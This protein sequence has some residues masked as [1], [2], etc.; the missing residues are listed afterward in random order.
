M[1]DGL[2]QVAPDSTGKKVDTSELIVG[3][4][5]VE[6]QRV[7]IGDPT[8]AAGLAA[9]GTPNTDADAGDIALATE[10][11]LKAWNGAS[12]DRLRMFS[13][14]GLQVAPAPAVAATTGAI[15][16]AATTVGP[17]TLNQYDGATV[18]VSG[19]YAGV[20]LSFEASNDNTLWFP[21][22]AVRSDSNIAEI[23]SGVLTAN[24][25]RAWDVELGEALYFRVRSTAWTS[26]SAAINIQ[27]GMFAAAPAMG[28]TA[29]AVYNTTL[30]TFT[31]GSLAYLLADVNG[32]AVIT[33]QG[34][35]AAA[36]AGTPVRIGGTFTT[37]LPTYTTGQQTDLQTTN[38]G[39][40]LVALSSGATAVAVK[41]ASTA[42]AATDPALTVSLSPNSPIVLPTPTASIINSAATTNATSVKAT[43]GTVYS[44]TASNTGAAVAYVKLYNLAA[45]PTVGT[46]TIAITIPV[47]A[48][49]TVN[50][51][52]GTS[53][54]RFSTG[55]A[56]AITN[57]GTDADATAVTAAQVKVIT[58]YI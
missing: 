14:G 41:A 27:L 48:G 40:V 10:S 15:T 8:N 39:E 23:T 13:L 1:A 45:A 35:A 29:H 36:I 11:Y 28:V 26:G 19:T 32:R 9:V 55:I 21:I 17:V 24:A 2:I 44:V 33:G 12:W 31:A 56:L 4:N 42:A 57:L 49:G 54:A 6:R 43:A 47:P 20:N 37:T 50:L 58:A 3:A 16:T 52:F 7:V 53:G 5:T 46:S 51:P 38:R 18:V 34:A 25:T 22:T 30:P